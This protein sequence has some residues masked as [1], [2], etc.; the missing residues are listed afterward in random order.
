MFFKNVK[1][2][3]FTTDFSLDDTV[4]QA[5]LE[6]LKFVNCSDNEMKST[7]FFSPLRESDE[8]ILKT[9]NNYLFKLKHENKI[10]PASVI[11]EELNI[12]V[13]E[14]ENETGSP[15]PKKIQ[16]DMREDIIYRLLPRAFSKT[17]YTNGYISIDKQMIV[18]EAS[19]DSNA[20]IFLAYLRKAI[21]SLPVVPFSKIRVDQHLTQWVFNSIPEYIEILD[22]AEFNSTAIDGGTVRCK[23]QDLDTDEVLGHIQA[24]KLVNKLAISYKDIL[25]CVIES[26]VSIK[27]LRFTDL[28][29]EQNSDIG[30]KDSA[31]KAIVDLDLF[32]GLMAEFTDYLASEFSIK[33]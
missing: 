5:Q 16:R 27:R 21:G 14:I 2:Y 3:K 17:T 32:A 11:N 1:L 15:V 31:H 28:V 4:L 19:S 33:E 30:P 20:E 24:G 26:D 13:E 22:E 6:A 7:G 25:S 29:L 12:R 10:L 23:N 18:I 9:G 8:L